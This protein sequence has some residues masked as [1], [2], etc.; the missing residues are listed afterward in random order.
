MVPCHYEANLRLGYWVKK[1]RA[2]FNKDIMDRER[3]EL[4]EQLGFACPAVK[5]NRRP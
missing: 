5:G 1:Q 4:L 2:D 3:K